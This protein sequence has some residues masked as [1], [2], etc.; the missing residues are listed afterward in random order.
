[1]RWTS[2]KS[3]VFKQAI[4][5]VAQ[6]IAKFGQLCFGGKAMALLQHFLNKAL[7]NTCK[8][9]VHEHPRSHYKTETRPSAGRMAF[10]HIAC[11]VA[12]IDTMRA[13]RGH[14]FGQGYTAR[15]NVPPKAI[16][17]SPEDFKCP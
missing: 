8:F 9:E 6:S 5:A 12:R 17:S 11:A 15:T 16:L 10:G 1:M 2:C 13:M 7:V 14:L 4:G 3:L